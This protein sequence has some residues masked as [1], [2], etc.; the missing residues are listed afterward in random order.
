LIYAASKGFVSTITRGMAKEL[1]PDHIRVNAVSPG[2]IMTPF[3][4]RFTTPEQLENFRKTIPIGP[5]RRTGRMR[6]RFPVSG[7]ESFVGLCHRTD[8][9]SQWRSVHALM[10][11]MPA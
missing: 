8:H 10:A 2:V 11:L 5:H 1:L 7:V 3:Q 4:E 6:R 9:R